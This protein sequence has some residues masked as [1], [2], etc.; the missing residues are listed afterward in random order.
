MRYVRGRR[1]TEAAKALSRGA[2]DIFSVALDAGY[3]SHEAFTRA[4]P[5][6]FGVTPETIRTQGHLKKEDVCSAC[7]ALACK[8]IHLTG[9]CPANSGR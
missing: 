1:L 5:D 4:F 3:G 2:P 8:C 7:N 9:C 6:E